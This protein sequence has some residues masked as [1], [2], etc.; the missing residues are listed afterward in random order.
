MFVLSFGIRRPGSQDR[1][2]VEGR[3]LSTSRA[4]HVHKVSLE[5]D[6]GGGEVGGGGAASSSGRRKPMEVLK[7]DPLF[8]FPKVLLYL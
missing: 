5:G 4:S 8:A 1:K 2:V 7:G 3:E 6:S